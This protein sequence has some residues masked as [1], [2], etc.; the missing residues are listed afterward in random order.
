M[1]DVFERAEA[2]GDEDWCPDDPDYR[3][4]RWESDRLDAD[5]DRMREE[6]RFGV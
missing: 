1:D 5:V 4:A 6:R 3:W 2:D